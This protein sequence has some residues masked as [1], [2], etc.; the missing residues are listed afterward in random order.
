MFRDGHGGIIVGFQHQRVEQIFHIVLI[1][2]L[3]TEMDLG[4]GGGIGACAH[5]FAGASGLQYEDSGHDLCRAGHG[6]L[7]TTFLSI[8]D[9]AGSA[10]HD[11]GVFCLQDG[12]G[13]SIGCG[14]DMYLL[15]W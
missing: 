7:L 8:K 13:R 1:T 11:T 3:H 15:F 5:R 6:G 12:S 10:V 14:G 4:H 2:L 9:A